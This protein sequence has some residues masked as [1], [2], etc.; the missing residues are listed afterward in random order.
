MSQENKMRWATGHNNDNNKN[1]LLSSYVV[2][3]VY[4]FFRGLE[5]RESIPLGKRPN[6]NN[7]NS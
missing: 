4:V 6:N 2:L 1:S 5:V 3:I 7:K